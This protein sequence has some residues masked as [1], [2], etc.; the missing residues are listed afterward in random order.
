MSRSQS[1][2]ITNISST[3]LVEKIACRVGVAF[4]KISTN[5]MAI[6]SFALASYTFE[7]MRMTVVLVFD[8]G[9]VLEE[10]IDW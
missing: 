10:D 9:G 8:L 5:I 6:L 4:V 3:Y 2:K 7:D 1:R